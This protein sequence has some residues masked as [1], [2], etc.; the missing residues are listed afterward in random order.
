MYLYFK[1]R[2]KSVMLIL[3]MKLSFQKSGI[4]FLNFTLSQEENNK[5]SL[6]FGPNIIKTATLNT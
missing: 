2:L 1:K 5:A 4:K 3:E 6:V